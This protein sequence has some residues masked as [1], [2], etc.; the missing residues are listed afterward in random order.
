MRRAE[1]SGGVAERPRRGRRH[2]KVDEDERELE[3]IEKGTHISHFRKSS[4]LFDN[5]SYENR[6]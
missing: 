2:M 4:L 5:D 1:G 6:R 3:I